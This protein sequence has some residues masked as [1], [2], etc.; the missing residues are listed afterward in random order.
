MNSP[1]SCASAMAVIQ[2]HPGGH[3][4]DVH[5]DARAVLDGDEGAAVFLQVLDEAREAE[6]LDITGPAHQLQDEFQTVA[7]F[8]AAVLVEKRGIGRG[9]SLE[10]AVPD[11]R[12][13]VQRL[14][15][16][17]FEHALAEQDIAQRAAVH[18][19]GVLED[20]EHL[21]GVGQGLAHL[22]DVHR[23]QRVDARAAPHLAA[24]M[25]DALARHGEDRA[26]HG[27]DHRLVGGAVAADKGVAQLARADHG[28]ACQL[29][30]DAAEDLRE[31]DAGI[32]P[33]AEQHALAQL[34]QIQSDLG[35]ALRRG[36]AVRERQRHVGAG[37]AVR[38]REDVQAVE[39]RLAVLQ[40][41]QAVAEH[42]LQL[43]TVDSSDTHA[44][45]PAAPF[46]FFRAPTWSGEGYS[47]T[48]KTAACPPRR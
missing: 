13:R 9:R 7:V 2:H 42:V 18:D 46:P 5:L 12:A 20:R 27:L 43:K 31:D 24:D 1:Y 6:V 32:A 11:E 29:Q 28:A 10:V 34:A 4:V 35:P 8:K 26:L 44:F 21:R 30:G 39:L 23:Q 3:R 38:D 41:R 25:L 45:T 16:E 36:D 48:Q 22:G 40:V 47:S 15:V 17:V 33:R 37:V 14:A 19:T